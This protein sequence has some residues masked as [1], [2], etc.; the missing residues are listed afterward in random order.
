[1]DDGEPQAE[2]G[3]EL[4]SRLPEERDLV[5][6]CR[7]LNAAGA[8]YVVI[9]GFA[10]INAGYPRTTVDIDLLIDPALDNEAA[11]KSVLATLPDNAV[12]EML[13]GEVTKYQVVRV[14]DEVTVDLM[15]SACGIDYWKSEK[16]IVWRELCGVRIPF[17][18]PRLLWAM[19]ATT[20]RDKDLGDLFFLRQEYANEIFGPDGKPRPL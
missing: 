18:S 20:H 17:A 3:E 12:N 11:V 8:R 15:A 5:E 16:H 10:V 13:P 7:G 2:Q 19:K 6:L 14:V 1:M 9:G 4:T